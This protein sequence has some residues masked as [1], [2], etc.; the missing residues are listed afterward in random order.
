MTYFEDLSPYTYHK[1]ETAE[2]IVNIGWLSVGNKL[3]TGMIDIKLL[4]KLKI[5][6]SQP[7][8]LY[9]GHHY[10]DFC[11]PKKNERT[12]RKFVR[13]RAKDHPC[14]NGELR[15]KSENGITYVAPTLI[16]HYIE[17]HHYLPPEEFLNIIQ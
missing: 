13:N 12:E 2:N 1:A 5:L 16:I 14:G 11:P 9:K 7:V 10:C 15:I 3:P 17:A 6:A 4:H 8:N